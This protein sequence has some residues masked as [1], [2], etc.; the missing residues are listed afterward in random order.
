[1]ARPPPTP[2]FVLRGSGAPINTLH[3]SCQEPSS[4]LLFSGSGKGAIHVWNLHTRRAE[5]VL[6]GHGGS[7]IVWVNTIGSKETLI[8]QARD[9]RLCTWNLSEGRSDV[10]QS[11]F[12]GSVGFCQGS[13]MEMHPQRWL[14]AYPAEDMEELVELPS[15]VPVC[16]LKPDAK[17][18]MLMCVKLWQPDGG[19]GPMLLAGY[20][21]G[22]LALWDVAQRQILSRLTT[23]PEPLLCLDFDPVGLRGVSG[24]AERAVSSWVLDGQQNLQ[25]R[26][27]VELVNPGISQLRLRMDR[28]ILA[29]AGW[30]HRIRLFSWKK[31]KPLAVLQYH[32]D[33]ALCVTFSDHK[34]SR[35]GLMAAG[36]KDQRISIWS[37]YN[38]S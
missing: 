38:D 5:R 6:E 12:T 11:I 3:F 21:D 23:H 33:T 32:T 29:S 31:L 13:V 28:R 37:V 25:L 15:G 9:K 22:S 20:E 2:L 36:S 19:C 27:T 10:T 4:A 14:L 24:S 35:L 30:D 1:M 17:L 34:D 8:S 18:G 7:S 26:D 16:S